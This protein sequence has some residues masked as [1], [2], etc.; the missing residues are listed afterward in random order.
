MDQMSL[1]ME[2]VNLHGSPAT[3]FV[4]VDDLKGLLEEEKKGSH[5]V[6]LVLEASSSSA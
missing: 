1:F 5:K 4:R 6:E 3:L 2:K